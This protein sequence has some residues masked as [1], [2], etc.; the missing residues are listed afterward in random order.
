MLA[1]E[2]I[3][4]FQHRTGPMLVAVDQIQCIRAM[5]GASVGC[6]LYLAGKPDAL[7]ILNAWDE[8]KDLIREALQ[9]PEALAAENPS[10]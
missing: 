9:I 4:V 3:V 10:D 7:Q 2:G 6:Y 5:S 1:N 8:A